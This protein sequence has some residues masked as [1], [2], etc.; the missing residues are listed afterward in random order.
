MDTLD[1]FGSRSAV[2]INQ[3]GTKQQINYKI[4]TIEK[5]D[6]I[7]APFTVIHPSGI[8]VVF[9]PNEIEEILNITQEL[10]A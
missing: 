2:F 6:L 9:K 3:P 1:I 8:R 5:K 10:V 4:T 7:S